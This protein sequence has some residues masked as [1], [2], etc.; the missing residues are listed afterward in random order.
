MTA[1]F[2]LTSPVVHFVE[3]CGLELLQ[4]EPEVLQQRPPAG[5]GLDLGLCP[6]YADADEA[7]NGHG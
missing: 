2:D 6:R 1:C 7:A 5:V 3:V 4:L